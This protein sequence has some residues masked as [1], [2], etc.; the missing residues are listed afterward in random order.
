MRTIR[1]NVGA[2]PAG[3]SRQQRSNQSSMVVAASRG[4]GLIHI[5]GVSIPRSGHNFVVRLLQE[6]FPNDLFYCEFYGI[7]G[8]CQAVPCVRRGTQPISFQKTHDFELN[9]PNDVAGATYLVMHR[10]P[11][12]AILSNREMYAEDYGEAIVGDRG[13]YTV[14]LGRNA[15]YYV[16]FYERWLERPVRGSVVVDYAEV[17][18]APAD[19]L[20]RLLDAIGLEADPSAIADAIAKTAPRGGL[21][22]ERPYVPRVIEKSR[23]LD[24]ELLSVFE[25]IIVD[26]IPHLAASRV[27][28]PVE[29]RG[30]LIWRV[31]EAIRA[32]RAGD[33]D[34][35][36]GL[37]DQA[38]EAVPDNGL[39]FYERASLLQEQRRFKEAQQSLQQAAAL[40]PMHPPI[41]EALVTVALAAGDAAAAVAPSEALSTLGEATLAER[42]RVAL[43]RAHS[44]E[45]EAASEL[46]DAV[47]QANPDDSRVWRL[48]SEIRRI[49]AEYRE[50][51]AAIDTAIR[52]AP[53]QG[54]LYYFRAETLLEFG[55]TDEAIAALEEALV[56]DSKQRDWWKLLLETL[57]AAQDG[58]DAISA[59]DDAR[60]NLP[61]DAE[62]HAELEVLRGRTR[63]L[64]TRGP[65]PGRR[66]IDPTPPPIEG[67][68]GAVLTRFAP[69][70]LLLQERTELYRQLAEQSRQLERQDIAL[71]Q[72]RAA[73]GVSEKRLYDTEVAKQIELEEAWG[74]THSLNEALERVH[75]ALQQ[76]ILDR[77]AAW[78]QAY[79]LE[80]VVQTLDATLAEKIKSLEEAWSQAH[81][82][83][84][85]LQQLNGAFRDKV[86]ELEAAWDH[87][88]RIDE[89][90][91][92]LR[93]ALEEKTSALQ[94]AWQHAHALDGALQ[95]R[96]AARQS[97]APV[98]SAAE[99]ATS[100]DGRDRE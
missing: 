85:A 76:N 40:L 93:E 38:I 24:R 43:I 28:E 49:R 3:S 46:L 75:Q 16:S 80:K 20:R 58:T 51:L 56:V 100:E 35:G 73:L 48:V 47:E 32:A 81:T 57:I 60:A 89:N 27:F 36:I 99:P 33:L 69:V 82:L 6:L 26:Q 79:E 77:R 45:T 62:F 42:L 37:L 21:F 91:Q 68:S 18:R 44:G 50:S 13:E 65:R 86:R 53:L 2:A 88:H 54:E 4:S 31:F 83:N 92:W 61:D 11:V 17:S 74:Q 9:V 72:V 66:R 84:Q 22:G 10:A 64:R 8:C 25:S 34:R 1:S 67:V 63:G 14:W 71:S 39:L 59:I 29:Y 7:A 90:S 98:A 12:P 94:A 55:R 41:L 19:V 23:Y 52:Q 87:A 95:H 78:N 96:D 30:T 5:I 70:Q 97:S 15:E